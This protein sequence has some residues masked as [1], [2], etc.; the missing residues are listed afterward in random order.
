MGVFCK[1]KPVAEPRGLTAAPNVVGKAGVLPNRLLLI[2]HDP[3]KPPA[4][5][6]H[7]VMP[8]YS[9]LT[10]EMSTGI[11]KTSM[12]NNLTSML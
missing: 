4:S 9:S 2:G 8:L 5:S 6:T 3:P 1:V 10:L 11:L 7:S 12:H